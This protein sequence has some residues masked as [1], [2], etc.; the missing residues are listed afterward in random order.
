MWN[1]AQYGK[2]G[3]ERDRPFFDLLARVDLDDPR[4]IADLGCGTAHQTA[5]LSDRWPE[6]HVV[7][8]DDSREMLAKAAPLTRPGRLELHLGD[9]ATFI[10]RAPLDLLV[11]N[12]AL[13]WVPDHATVLPEMRKLS[14]L[15]I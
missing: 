13:H 5:M 6:A 11:S 2:F 15:P 10:P 1:P 4:E 14:S 9:L 12:A 3:E 8:V 7:G